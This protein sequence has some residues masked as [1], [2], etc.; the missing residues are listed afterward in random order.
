M[1]GVFALAALVAAAV[2][3]A[4]G[5]SSTAH[6]RQ[7]VGTTGPGFTITLTEDGVPVTDIAPGTYWLTVHDLSANHNFH[8]VGVDVDET[9]TTVPQVG[10]VTVK[11]HLRQGDYT[12]KCDPHAVTRLMFGTFT[13][14]GDDEDDEEDEDG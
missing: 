12:Y 10:D 7:L 11:I 14:S 1:R 6:G 8:L 2:V 4:P 13:V 3:V 9:V 5:V